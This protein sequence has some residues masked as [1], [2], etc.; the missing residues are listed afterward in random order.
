MNNQT[1]W[2][3][4]DI[5][6]SATPLFV[7]VLVVYMARKQWKTAREVAI[8][9]HNKLKLDLFDRR[10][11]IYEAV[12]TL[13]DQITTDFNPKREVLDSFL[14]A[15]DEADFLFNEEIPIYL[16]DL[17]LYGFKLR[18]IWQDLDQKRRIRE[19]MDVKLT[20]EH[21]EIVKAVLKARENLKDV[22]MPYLDFRNVK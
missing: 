10:F 16:D 17:R 14:R 13:L 22:F 7:G 12:K 1:Y 9:N 4:T 20:D 15:I 8:T 3:I 6:K 21:G 2:Y 5:L 19:D 11:R 18:L